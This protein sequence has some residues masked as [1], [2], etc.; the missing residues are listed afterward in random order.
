MS[1]KPEGASESAVNF[2]FNLPCSIFHYSSHLIAYHTE[3]NFITLICRQNR[4]D[5]VSVTEPPI[6]ITDF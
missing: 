3:S 2:A 4:S 6:D 5:C 1:Q